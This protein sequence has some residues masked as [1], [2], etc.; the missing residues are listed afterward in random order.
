MV[1]YPHTVAGGTGLEVV[2]AGPPC[3]SMGENMREI[4]V[5]LTRQ[6]VVCTSCLIYPNRCF[7]LRHGEVASDI[8]DWQLPGHEELRKSSFGAPKP[9]FRTFSPLPRNMVLILEASPTYL[10][11]RHLFALIRHDRHTTACLV[12]GYSHITPYCCRGTGPH[13]R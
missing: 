7:A 6:A 3:N 9:D 11:R 13:H 8:H 1:G 2:R 12:S 4:D 5:P 10:S